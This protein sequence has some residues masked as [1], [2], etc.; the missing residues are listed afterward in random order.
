MS[1]ETAVFFLLTDIASFLEYF[2]DISDKNVRKL[3]KNFPDNSYAQQ[4]LALR[5]ADRD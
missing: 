4:G 1:Y 3:A 2:G 5:F